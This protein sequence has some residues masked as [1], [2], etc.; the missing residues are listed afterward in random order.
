MP[1]MRKSTLAAVALVV[2]SANSAM[3]AKITPSGFP[4]TP[5][6]G[7]GGAVWTESLRSG[8][9]AVKAGSSTGPE[10]T[11]GTFRPERPLATVLFQWLAGSGSLTLTGSRAFSDDPVSGGLTYTEQYAG[12]RL[13][14]L[15]RLTRCPGTRV[16]LRSFDV[17]GDAYAFRQCDDTGGHVEIRDLGSPPLGPSR[18]V[19]SGG[20]GTRIAG[21]YVAWLDGSYGEDVSFN[22]G[23]I[24]VYDRVAGTEV[25]RVPRG[26]LTAPIRSLDVQDDGKI[27]VAFRPDVRTARV[28]VGWA[29]PQEPQVHLLPLKPMIDYH[30]HIANNTIAFERGNDPHGVTQRAE[31]GISDLAGRTHIVA[32]HTDDSTSEEGFDYD[33]HRLLWRQLGCEHAQLMIQATSTTQPPDNLRPCPL[34][35]LRPPTYRAGRATFAINCGPFQRPCLF[36][37]S[38]RIGSAH[39][40][41]AGRETSRNPVRV[42]LSPAAQHTLKHHHAILVHVRVLIID[43][44]FRAQVRTAN[45]TLRR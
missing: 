11:V 9:Y 1:M 8:G 16:G 29:S 38:L 4:S 33:G 40:P 30:V 20:F 14:P 31:V 22:S 39:G 37:V 7:G 23:D 6:L 5:V 41:R 18:S 13:G 35:L 21:R 19:G 28:A 17:S 26:E 42:K 45:V 34:R 2:L 3:A 32:R 44:A 10:V 24:V 27:A 36:E 43:A 25:Y 12:P 15:E